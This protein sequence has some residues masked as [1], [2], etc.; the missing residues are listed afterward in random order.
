MTPIIEIGGHQIAQVPGDFPEKDFFPFCENFVIDRFNN[1]GGLHPISLF[2]V[3]TFIFLGT[4]DFRDVQAKEQAMKIARSFSKQLGITKY[5]FASEI[6]AKG[7]SIDD[8]AT[9]SEVKRL[10]KSGLEGEPDKIERLM[11]VLE[12]KGARAIHIHFDISR[13]GGKPT[14]IDR[15]EQP[16]DEV[17][18]RAA[19]IL[20]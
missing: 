9:P 3:D 19:G 20:D 14:L 5:F 13:K 15:K 18:G 7:F 10:N 11:L 2:F 8:P 4:W 16:F 6:W 1:K 17:S 12:T